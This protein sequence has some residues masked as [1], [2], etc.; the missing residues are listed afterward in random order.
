MNDIIN[1]GESQQMMN[2]V[3]LA[4][5]VEKK[6][7]YVLEAIRKMEPA[8]EKIH[9]T[10]FRLMLREVVAGQ[11]ARRMEPCYQLT[12]LE[13]LYIA[14]KF[15]DE[16][17]AKL[18]K[19]W[20]ELETGEATPM[21]TKVQAPIAPKTGAELLLMYAEQMVEQER[22]LSAIETRQQQVEEK[23]SEIAV[24]T[25]TEVKYS[26]IIGFASRHGISVPLEKAQVLGKVA[27]TQCASFGLETGRVADPRFGSV[28]TYPDSILLD[29]FEKYYPNIRFR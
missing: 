16:S 11:G 14:T 6:H 8:W 12:K 4:K 13:S 17:R 29:V 19:R 10:K 3:E 26:T 22:K 15:K 21:V 25:K 18:V 2:S 1:F 27:T 23:V 28:R 24:R 5:V 7:K 9:G 20:E